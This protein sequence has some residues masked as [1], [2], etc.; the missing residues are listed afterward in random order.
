VREGLSC[1]P[2]FDRTCRFGHT[3][4]LEAIEPARVIAVLDDVAGTRS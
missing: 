4:C 1:S 3:R 2:C